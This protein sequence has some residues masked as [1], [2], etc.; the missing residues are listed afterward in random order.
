MSRLPAPPKN[1]PLCDT[2]W[3]AINEQN[4]AYC[5]F[6]D[7]HWSEME[8]FHHVGQWMY[9]DGEPVHVLAAPNMSDET[10]IALQEL[11]RA[12]KKMLDDRQ[13]GIDAD[14]QEP[15]S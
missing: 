9:V 12:A 7:M 14:E 5:A 4:N 10:Y 2:M 1:C 11:V 8:D 13:P 6:D 3:A 15:T